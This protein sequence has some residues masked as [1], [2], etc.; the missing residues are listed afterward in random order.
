MLYEEKGNRIVEC[1]LC[2][3]RCRIPEGSL[4]FCMVRRN[5]DG[6]LYT[7]VYGKAIAVNADPIEKKPLLHFHPGSMV[8]SIATIGC[9]FRCKFC[10]NWA[11]SQETEI[12]GKEI[13]PSRVVSNAL[14]LKCQGVSYTYTEPTVFFEY[15]YDT[16]KIAKNYNLFNTFV[17]NG[18]MT[19]EAVK[20]IAPYLNAATVDFKGSADP[21]FYREVMS[22]P[23]PEPIFNTIKEMKTQGIFIEI[24][25]LIVTKYGDSIER[26]YQLASRI[27]EILGPYTPFHVLRF[28]PEYQL[29][30]V[31]LTPIQTLEKAAETA[32]NAGLKH[33]YIGNVLGHKLESTY[34]PKCGLKIVERYGFNILDWK[35]K[36]DNTCPQCSEKINI[37]GKYVGK[38]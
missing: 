4:G 35:L 36:E 18:Y 38:A 22:V 16:A 23:D 5:I 24:T 34:C 6:K 14:Q 26:V 33:V 2:Y 25:N 20:T 28:Y 32:L 29:T 11:I 21:K 3:R 37:I 27:K 1:K 19:E 15:A 31:N 12:V 9:N 30:D 17:T 8:M 10:D 13:P 7:L